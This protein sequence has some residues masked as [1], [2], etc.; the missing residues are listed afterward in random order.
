MASNC[1]T[2]LRGRVLRF[3][4]LDACGRPVVG[5]GASLVTESFTGATFGPEIEEGEEIIK[6]TASG[7]T[8]VADKGPDTI[9]WYNFEVT[10]CAIDPE[11]ALMFN[12]KW[13]PELDASGSVIG[14]R[15]TTD[16]SLDAGYAVEMWTDLAGADVCDNPDALGAWGYMLLPWVVG[17]AMG[18]LEITGEAPDIVFTGRAKP[19]ARWGHG[20]YN[21]IQD[22][23]GAPS[24][25]LT[26]IGRDVLF[27]A[28]TITTLPP[29]EPVCG[30]Q[31]LVPVTPPEPMTLSA[32]QDGTDPAK[33]VF[34]VEHAPFPQ[35]V[36]DYGDNTDST[37]HTAVDGTVAD[38]EHTYTQ[39]P[40]S[41]VAT[42]TSGS[43]SVTAPVTD[44]GAP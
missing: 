9:K 26:P 12:P 7:K 20:P 43:S 31:E 6:K 28:P 1:Y 35:V 13:Q 42:A 32:V 37:E 34:T 30:A 22:G 15:V 3:T 40:A 4:R 24:P 23:T 21:V 29:P 5:P 18:D 2:P 11:L 33:Y 41:G 38:V 25:L 8:C 16:T 27:L 14:W 17:G 44:I 39:V 10:F 36:L 19:G